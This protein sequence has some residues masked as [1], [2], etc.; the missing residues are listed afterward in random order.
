MITELLAMPPH[1]LRS[2]GRGC[3]LIGP[4]PE[5]PL[6]EQAPEKG[7]AMHFANKFAQ[8]RLSPYKR[9][10]RSPLMRASSQRE[11][12]FPLAWLVVFAQIGVEMV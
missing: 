11:L 5:L 12:I 1:E 6:C 3:R 4:K 10:K 8:S 7:F 9:K 2:F